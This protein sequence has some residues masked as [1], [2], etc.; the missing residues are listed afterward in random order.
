MKKGICILLLS[1]VVILSGCS[2][3]INLI[4]P[5]EKNPTYLDIMVTNK[6]LYTM[7]KEIAGNNN[8]DYM[9]KDENKI[10]GFSYTDD[11]IQNV[12][13]QDLFIYNGSDFEKWSEDFLGKVDKNKVGVINV[14]RG[15][16]LLSYNNKDDSN[17]RNKIPY[18]W[19]DADNYKVMLLN[20]KN[21]I[22]EKDPNNRDIY[23]NNFAND[24]KDIDKYNKNMEKI[25]NDIKQYNFVTDSDDFDYLLNK[26]DNLKF[27]RST[28]G[29]ISSDDLSRI[30]K[31]MDNGKKL[32]FMYSD[33]KDLQ[34]NKDIIDKFKLKTAKVTLYNGDMSYL[35]I[36]QSNLESIKKAVQ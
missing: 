14:S 2:E 6:C 29:I 34:Q 35:D 23:E 7:V 16:S 15:V 32:C 22:E 1:F 30:Q 19:L 12:G 17:Y 28:Q 8:I 31:E 3:N 27:Y 11:S 9:F 33:D 18:Y 20:I 5:P 4:V 26:Y 21:A 10:E 13:K 24:I 36:L 25:I